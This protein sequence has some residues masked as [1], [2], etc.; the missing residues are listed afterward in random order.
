MQK[1]F[2]RWN[3]EKKSIDSQKD[4]KLYHAQEI[5]WCR[6]GVNVGSEQDGTGVE[7]ERPIL[8]IKGLSRKTCIILPLTSSPQKHP[9]RIPLGIIEGR[10]ASAILSQIRVIDTKRLIEKVCFLERDAFEPI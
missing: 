5:W 4:L 1:D 9:M 2:D 10:S 7:F 3:K 6:L 8:I